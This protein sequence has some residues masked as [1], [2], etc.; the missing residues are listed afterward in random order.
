M[1]LIAAVAGVN[2]AISIH[3]LT[4]RVTR[5]LAAEIKGERISIHTLTQRVT[6][7]YVKEVQGWGISIHTL[8]QRVTPNLILRRGRSRYFNPH[9]HAE[10][11][12][13]TR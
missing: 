3:T 4:Q 7:D 8:T 1:T 10:G 2:I 5:E 12:T 13:I 6:N 9:P 11:D